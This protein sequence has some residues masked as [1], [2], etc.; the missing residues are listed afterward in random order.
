LNA[1]R[2]ILSGWPSYICIH[3][4]C[5]YIN[6]V[7]ICTHTY[8]Y[9]YTSISLGKPSGLTN[10]LTDIYIYI[11]TYTHKRTY[12]YIHTQTRI[13]IH[14]HTQ[15]H[16]Y[17]H[18]YTSASRG[19]PSGLTNP[20]TDIYIYIYIY[21]Y[22]FKC[23]YIYKHICTYVYIYTDA[24]KHVLPGGPFYVCTYIYIYI[25]IYI[26]VHFYICI[27]IYNQHH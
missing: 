12:T 27:Y 2:H 21:G 17:I 13:Y 25:Y 18:I 22:I 14:K 10:P 1:D 16:I 20:L 15:T 7:N 11:H 8:I 26:Y 4:Y 19:K 3:V 5:I 9:M 23:V 6:T 24:E